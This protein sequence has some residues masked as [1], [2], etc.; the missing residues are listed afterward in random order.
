V[1]KE[2]ALAG[3]E[4]LQILEQ[5][6][7]LAAEVEAGKREPMNLASEVKTE[8]L[9]A[10]SALVRKLEALRNEPAIN[11]EK[12]DAMIE[13]GRVREQF[14]QTLVMALESDDEEKMEEAQRLWDKAE[15]Y[16]RK[17]QETM[18]R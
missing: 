3:H 17:Q 12:F 14:F 16:V 18:P 8:I 1:R 2:L 9:P 5:Y 7:S 15:A 4:E 10:W 13:Y 6:Q 11:R